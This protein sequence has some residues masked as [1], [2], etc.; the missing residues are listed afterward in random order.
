M[1]RLKLFENFNIDSLKSLK[2]FSKNIRNN[3]QMIETFVIELIENLKDGKRFSEHI[4]VEES[5]SFLTD[6]LFRSSL[7]YSQNFKP[8]L[9]ISLI[10]G[11]KVEKMSDFITFPIS[12][13][14]F[15]ELSNILPVKGYTPSSGIK[16]A[17]NQRKSGKISL[18]D[19][20]TLVPGTIKV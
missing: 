20:F 2:S 15:I 11:E 17:A 14:D 5:H 6:P 12:E 8:S 19:F 13:K 10:E 1:R 9:T 16:V 18:M 3:T 7:T 4:F